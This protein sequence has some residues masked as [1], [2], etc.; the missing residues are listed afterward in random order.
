[1]FIRLA[2]NNQD[3]QPIDFRRGFNAIVAERAEDSSD[4]HTRN[5]RGK[6]TLIM[7]MN[8]ALGGNRHASLIPLAEDEWEIILT[9]EM[10]GGQVTV[11][12]S[13]ANGSRVNLTATEPAA[14]FLAS[15]MSEGSVALDDWK[16]LLGLALFQLE[17]NGDDTSSGGLSVRTLLSYVIR[18][19][20]PK[21]PLKVVQ[22]Q[23]A[24]SS[25]EHV[26]FLLGLN[27]TVVRD[28][29]LVQRG[30]DQI[31]TINTATREGLVPS[32]RLEED[33]ALERAGIQ[34]EIDEWHLRISA[35]RILEDP[36][37]LVER[38]DQL[39]A[40]LAELRD[41]AVVD[42]RMRD[43]YRASLADVDVQ[44]TTGP[45]VEAVLELA[46]IALA[47]G[48]K[49]RID[50]V[51]AFHT[52][53]LINRR[54][55]LTTEIGELDRRISARSEELTQLDA[56]RDQALRTL[57]AGGALE[58]LNALRIELGEAQGRMAAVEQQIAQ[59]REL[60]KTRDALKVE[61]SNKRT[62]ATRELD[63][64]RAKVDRISE[65][66]RL[67]MRQ[68]YNKDAALAVSVDDNGYKF[69]IKA[70]GAGSTGVDRMTLFCFDLTM[71][72]EGIE[73]KHHPDFLV[74]DSSVFDG[75]DPR[76][77]AGAMRF[78]Q[79]LVLL[80]GGQYICTINSNDI[81]DDVLN[82]DW[83][84][85]GVVRSVLDTELGG[86]VGRDF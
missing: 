50:D 56:H 86:L 76:Q 32:L 72:E 9:L 30:L 16:A 19:E 59:A 20:T 85:A 12:R 39:T 66:F 63:T 75:V 62:D 60:V 46:G 54:S 44:A 4:Q 82:E 81:P 73:S 70:S 26:S 61:Q 74:H 69:T 52:S 29:A 83:F 1:M 47:D 21:D 3:F 41:D 40:R 43:L 79:E 27:W 18:S 7:F 25:R 71:L 55:F 11:T 42:V 57:E 2:T 15:W 28:L 65:R 49:R 6:S 33:L 13:L 24:T 37:A 38:A 53:L 45:A 58:E 77:R 22:T 84:K 17:P 51:R 36:N 48:I 10:F 78:A 34:N 14:A 80:T 8:Y 35:F 23:S 31:K 68:L 5:A 64:S 67:K